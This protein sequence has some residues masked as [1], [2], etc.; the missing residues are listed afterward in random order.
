MKLVSDESLE[1]WFQ[2]LWDGSLDWDEANLKKLPK[3]GLMKHHVENLL[4]NPF[5]LEGKIVEPENE[6]WNE[7]RFLLLG[8]LDSGKGYALIFT[9]RKTK[10]R[11]ITCRR[12]RQNEEKKFQKFIKG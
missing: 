5:S 11:L 2:K 10:L 8:S 3:H 6:N 4:S 9:I 1:L 12:M 7:S